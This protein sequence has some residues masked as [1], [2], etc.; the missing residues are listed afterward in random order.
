MRFWFLVLKSH[1]LA[2]EIGYLLILHAINPSMEARPPLPCGG[3]AYKEIL[4]HDTRMLTPN[5]IADLCFEAVRADIF[6][7]NDTFE[8]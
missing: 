7:F 4:N 2:I 6:P 5:Q 1:S 8:F 3:T